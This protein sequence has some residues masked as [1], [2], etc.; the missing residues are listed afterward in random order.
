MSNGEAGGLRIYFLDQTGA[1]SLEA[2]V[3]PAV[4]VSRIIP[5]VVT[6][7]N[8]PVTAPDGSPMRY[9]LDHKEGGRR[10]LDG[11]TLGE[12]GVR[13]GDHL[14]V[15]PEIVAGYESPRLRRLKS[16]FDG[17]V[18]LARESTIFSFRA[19]DEDE[20]P[21]RYLL[22]FDG[23]GLEP[24][25]DGG[26]RVRSHHEVEVHL[27]SSYPRLKPELHW[28]TPIFHP[29]VSAAGGVCLGGYTTNWVPSL[30]L[31]ELCEMLWDMLRYANFDTR[32]AYN[33]VAARWASTQNAYHFPL[34]PR[35]LRDLTAAPD[36]RVVSSTAPVFIGMD[37]DEGSRTGGGVH[38][39]QRDCR[40]AGA[41]RGV[42]FIG[43]EEK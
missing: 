42:V 13:D 33:R 1:K 27:V 31:A 18:K 36:T 16:D 26:V 8:L 23:R 12:A 30:S 38:V 10:L 19:L 20:P 25:G 43:E 35:R 17:L 11:Q 34:D 24:D 41:P 21:S 15:Y 9:C 7:M 6:E 32:S 2:V 29:N 37:G 28:R 4:E 40:G 22:V 5:R 3:S 14:V 39:P